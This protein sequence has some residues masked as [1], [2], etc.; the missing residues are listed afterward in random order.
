MKLNILI[1]SRGRPFQLAAALYSLFLNASEEHDI[2]FCVACD[3][4]DKE[5]VNALR[6]LRP[7]M[8]LFVRCGPRPESLGSVANDLA[9]HWPADAYVIFADDLICSTY[10][11]DAKVASAIEKTPHGVFWWRAARG[12]PTF[13]PIVTEKWRSA[14]GCIFTEH[15]PFWYDDLW[16]YELWIMTSG[17]VPIELDIDVVDKPRSTLGMRELRFW[18]DFYTFMRAERVASS[19]R[20]AEKLGLQP[21]TVFSELIAEKFNGMSHVTDDFLAD[22]MVKN[23][24]ETGEPSENYL[25][26]KARAENLMRKVA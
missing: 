14:A 15:F 2:Q 3:E 24:A 25:R 4:D 21:Q 16:L 19:R 9:A 22:I 5:T 10:G 1:P 23:K 18:H 13:V 8:P 20:I 12:V 26:A 17:D 7:K 6:A 11:W